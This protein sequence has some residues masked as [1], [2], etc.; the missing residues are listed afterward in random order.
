MPPKWVWLARFF[1]CSSISCESA[2]DVP[3][4]A[5]DPPVSRCPHRNDWW[6]IP[7]PKTAQTYSLMYHV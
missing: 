2:E 7:F 5:T 3:L 1:G 4:T 6:S